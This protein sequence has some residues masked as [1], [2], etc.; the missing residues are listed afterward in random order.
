MAL[1]ALN[2]VAEAA[3]TIRDVKNIE[4]IVDVLS[5]RTNNKGVGTLIAEFF[6]DISGM[7]ATIEAFDQKGKNNR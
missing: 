7:S 2:R 1:Y 4:K 5:S 3:R 6:A